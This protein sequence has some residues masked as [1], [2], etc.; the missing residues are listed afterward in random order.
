V[1]RN[2]AV[3]TTPSGDGE[4]LFYY[5]QVADNDYLRA[6]AT[7]GIESPDE[8]DGLQLTYDNV[9]CTGTLA[10]G[11]GQAVRLTTAVPVRVPLTVAS[12]N[13][14]DTAGGVELSWQLTDTRPVVGWRV[15]SLHNGE[16]TCLTDVPLAADARQIVVDG[17]DGD[18]VLEALLPHGG[19]CEAGKAL[20]D[21]AMFSF[22]LGQP[23]PN[24]VR[25]ESSISFSLPRQGA[26]QLRV[27]DVR[28]R[29]VRTLM[30]GQ[31]ASGQGLVV[32]KG[33]DDQGRN[34]ADGVYFYRLEHEGRT[35]TRKL[36]LVR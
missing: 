25:G 13:R 33:R 29:L 2:P 15:F 6:Y 12:L 30:D 1:L 20:A 11:P 35:L 18:L 27:F 9:R 19:S 7:V 4:I 3:H 21:N 22:A 34:L 23:V 17:A 16:K 28:G 14:R 10:F 8:T 36:L 5:K 32:W 26:M 24:P 31:A